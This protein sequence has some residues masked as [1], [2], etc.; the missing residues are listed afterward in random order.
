[1]EKRKG[2]L[3]VRKD[4]PQD[5]DCRDHVSTLPQ[6]PAGQQRP[7]VIHVLH[8][9]SKIK[10]SSNRAMK[11]YVWEARF[12]PTRVCQIEKKARKNLTITF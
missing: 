4:K 6:Q 7:D 9:Q 2:Q 8:V 11:L 5:R 10:G 12:Q 3:E 1:M